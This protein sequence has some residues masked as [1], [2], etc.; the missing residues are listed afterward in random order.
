MKLMASSFYN[1]VSRHAYN[2]I[3]IVSDCIFL[4]SVVVLSGFSW[5]VHAPSWW[6]CV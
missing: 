1:H 5:L 6:G 4:A 2:K 3:L